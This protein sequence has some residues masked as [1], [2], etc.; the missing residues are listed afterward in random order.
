[1]D[2]LK[3]CTGIHIV[4]CKL[5]TYCLH[6]TKKI[7]HVETQDFI[8]CLYDDKSSTCKNFINNE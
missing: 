4:D 3:L 2:N 7:N 8:E 1:M 6:Y 5:K